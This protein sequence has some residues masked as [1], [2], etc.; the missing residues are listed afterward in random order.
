MPPLVGVPGRRGVRRPDGTFTEA[1]L[2][3][4]PSGAGLP[5]ATAG[6]R[7]VYDPGRLQVEDAL[8]QFDLKA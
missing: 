6:H 3:V 8:A 7:A 1:L 2:A 5:A 4:P